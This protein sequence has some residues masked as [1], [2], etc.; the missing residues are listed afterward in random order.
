MTSTKHLSIKL[1]KHEVYIRF[2]SLSLAMLMLFAVLTKGLHHFV[3]KQHEVIKTCTDT[4]SFSKSHI[5]GADYL[6]HNCALCDFTFTFFSFQLPFFKSKISELI[7]PQKIC[8][9]TSLKNSNAQFFQPL[10]G[11]PTFI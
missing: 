6:A 5:H 1:S 7:S 8:L 2:R 9:Y 10:R 11:P 3:D 4:N